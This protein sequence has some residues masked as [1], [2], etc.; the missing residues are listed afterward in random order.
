[1]M[2]IYKITN[3]ITGK[4]YIGQSVNIAIRWSAHKSV[5][6]SIETLDGNDL[7]KDMLELGINNF[8]FD[9]LEETTVDKLDEREIYWIQYYNTYYDGYNQTMGGN[10]NIRLDY[11]K[12]ELLWQQGMTS[13]EISQILNYSQ[14]TVNSALTNL[15]ITTDEKR[16]RSHNL[17]TAA[18]TPYQR[19]VVKLN[20]ETN[21][22]IE[23][24]DSVSAAAKSL[25]IT[26]ASF[27]E[28]VQK[29]NNIYKDYKWIINTDTQI[30]KKFS[31]K[32]VIKLDPNTKEPI[33]VFESASAAARAMN[34]AG[35]TL[36]CR[37]CKNNTKS[38]GFYWKYIDNQ[39]EINYEKCKTKD[40]TTLGHCYS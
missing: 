4:S 19:A 7:H 35:A 6:R 24:F 12:I 29:H 40:S 28:G 20:P 27:R 11:N 30:E 21:E 26:R 10:G 1:M 15:N 2:G 8:S 13:K 3:K 36:I 5:S 39:E 16:Q 25:G 9:I 22:I 38:R 14:N 31:A 32:P 33:E 18:Y 23:T 37:A 17:I 34:L